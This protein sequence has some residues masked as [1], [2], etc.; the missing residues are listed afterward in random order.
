M[1]T[2]RIICNAKTGTIRREMVENTAPAWID[3]A[4]EMEDCKRR[5]AETDYVSIK[6]AEGV[7]TREDYREA[8]AMRAALRL[9]IGELEKQ[10]TT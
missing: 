2:E 8:L 4:A 10:V 3:Y 1:M 7:A 5:L 6:I 9:R